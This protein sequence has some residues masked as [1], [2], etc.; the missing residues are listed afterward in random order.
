MKPK[1]LV[2]L[3]FGTSILASQTTFANSGPLLLSSDTDKPAVLSKIS[4]ASWASSVFEQMKSDV[5][6]Y[7]AKTQEQEDW[8]YSRLAMNWDTKYTTPIISDQKMVSGEGSAEIATPRFAGSRD[9]NTEYQAPSIE[10]LRPYND[11]DGK[12][13]LEHKVTGVQ[14]LVEPQKSGHS[15]EIINRNIMKVASEAAFLYWITNDEKYA[16]FSKDILWTY[17]AG[18]AQKNEP[19]IIDNNETTARII[20]VTSHEVIHEDIVKSI[21]VAYD[22][23]RDYVDQ[24]EAVVVEQGIKRIIDRV[25]VGGEAHGNWNLHQAIQIAYGGLALKPNDHYE[26]KKGR[27]YYISIVLDADLINQMGVNEVIK[28]GYDL[29]SGVWPEAPSYA[30]D[31]TSN[32][33]EIASLLSST[34]GGAAVLDSPTI[35]AAIQSQVQQT[36]PS[37][38]SHG[39]GNSTYQRVNAKLLENILAWN[40][41]R[42]P[43]V[44]KYVSSVLGSEIDGGYYDR[45][46]IDN[47][48]FALTKYIGELH[49]TDTHQVDYPT[50]SFIKPLNLVLQRSLVDNNDKY[51]SLGSAIYGTKGKHMQANGLA[52]E[53]FGAGHVQA[54]DPG[55]GSSY[56][57]GDH[58]DFYAQLPAHNTVIPN[59]N[60]RYEAVV[61]NALEPTG[62]KQEMVVNT[63][64][65]DIGSLEVTPYNYV[66]ASMVYPEAIQ[67]R[68][69]AQVRIDEDTAFFFDVFRSKNTKPSN[70]EYH[71]WFFHSMAD[72]SMLKSGALKPSQVLTSKNGNH[73]GYD[74]FSNEQSTE[75]TESLLVTFQSQI[76]ED[77][78][79]INILMPKASNRTVFTV[80]SPANRAG[81]FYYDENIWNKPTKSLMVRQKG[82]AWDEPFVAVYEPYISEVGS[83]IQ[84]VEQTGIN[85]WVVKGPDWIRTLTLNDNKLTLSN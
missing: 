74:Y 62:Q 77:D 75:I 23:L 32:I 48:I 82:D 53:L 76:N 7:V 44:A 78:I 15:I 50:I 52:I 13:Y 57:Q 81:R 33:I 56:W 61:P 24:N 20:G 34:D 31:T 70:N 8:M 5:D 26:D 28:T 41:E 45:H 42:N 14:S 66:N 40:N 27:E 85:E 39:L 54:I 17:M 83:Q 4:D 43:Q 69:L 63:T 68:T 12:L 80:D 22:Y 84:S 3:L 58:Q 47:R 71:D 16:K 51:K 60:L 35:S 30:F 65:P 67:N 37:G 11:V 38:Q 55:R 49:E 46:T 2:T 29:D 72:K 73:K 36:Y 9:W 79:A 21:A 25:I 6:V 18:L 1:L 19:R 59:G 10:D 64:Y